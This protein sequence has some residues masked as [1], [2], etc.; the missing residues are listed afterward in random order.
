MKRHFITKKQIA[1]IIKHYGGLRKYEVNESIEENYFSLFFHEK[2]NIHLWMTVDCLKRTD[3]VIEVRFTD[4]TG[5]IV[6]R[7][8]WVVIAGVPTMKKGETSCDTD[9]V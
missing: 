3:D 4:T 2:K 7:D 1:A 5:L 9:T 6:K 8:R